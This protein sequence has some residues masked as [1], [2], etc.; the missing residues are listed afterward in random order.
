MLLNSPGSFA[1][2]PGGVGGTA[3]KYLCSFFSS[4]FPFEEPFQTGIN[5]PEQQQRPQE[6]D[7]PAPALGAKQGRAAQ[8]KNQQ[9]NRA[10]D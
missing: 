1:R 4:D 2:S 7:R 9:R 8:Q 10:A 6:N 3:V 5:R